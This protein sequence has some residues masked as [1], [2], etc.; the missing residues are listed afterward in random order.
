MKTLPSIC[1]LAAIGFFILTLV[2][3]ALAGG[4][5]VTGIVED[6]TT[7]SVTVRST[8]F[9]LTGET[10]YKNGSSGDLAV[11]VRV[12]VPVGVPVGVRVWVAVDVLVLV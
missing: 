12:K 11:G 10:E 9:A 1:K 7:D 6:V 5:N 8:T 3:P 4:M 2:P